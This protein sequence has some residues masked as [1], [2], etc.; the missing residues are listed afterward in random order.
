MSSI[1]STELTMLDSRHESAYQW[2]IEHEHLIPNMS[3]KEAM[4]GYDAGFDV[5]A[6]YNDIIKNS[7]EKV[8]TT[9]SQ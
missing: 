7:Y 6:L 5:V 4:Y 1:F 9:R 2:Y 8:Y 3:M